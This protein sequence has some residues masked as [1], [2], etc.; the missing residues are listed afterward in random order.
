VQIV[1]KNSKGENFEN[2]NFAILAAPNLFFEKLRFAW[3]F[4]GI[5]KKAFETCEEK[6]GVRNQKSRKQGARAY[7]RRKQRAGQ[8]RS[9]N[10]KKNEK[11]V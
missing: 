3:W 2:W 8:L 9:K 10:S 5:P 4:F 6:K 1:A 11:K 7:R